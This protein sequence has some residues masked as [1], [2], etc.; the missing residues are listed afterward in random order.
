MGFCLV[1]PFGMLTASHILASHATGIWG[2]K[3]RMGGGRNIMLSWVLTFV[4]L[5]I[6]TGVL[7][8]TGIAGAAA[9]IAKILFVV[10]I[11]MLVASA[12]AH[13]LR[14]SPQV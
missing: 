8:F 10:F 12:V 1:C 13:A 11:V 7:G 3:I 5:A 6:I 2:D 9:G 14:G 4:I